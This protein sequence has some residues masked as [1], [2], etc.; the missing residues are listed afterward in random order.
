M[1]WFSCFELQER[2][3]SNVKHICVWMIYTEHAGIH[4]VLETGD[5]EQDWMQSLIVP[6]EWLSVNPH[7]NCL[8]QNLLQGPTSEQDPKVECHSRSL[9]Y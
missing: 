7:M 9:G 6:L 4:F 8:K 2:S 5:G 1:N 3:L